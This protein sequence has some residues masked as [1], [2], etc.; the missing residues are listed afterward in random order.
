MEGMFPDCIFCAATL[1]PPG[2][3]GGGE[4]IIPEFLMGSWCTKDV[5][6]RCNHYFGANVDH[7]ALQDRRVIDTIGHLD[8][9]I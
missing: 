5:C 4:H 6:A 8:C 9:G 7:L 2:Q 1:A 3:R